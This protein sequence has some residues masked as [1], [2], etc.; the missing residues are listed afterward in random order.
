MGRELVGE[1]RISCREGSALGFGGSLG[2]NITSRCDEDPAE[3]PLI[4]W[5]AS[6][7]SLG[8]NKLPKDGVKGSGG[9]GPKRN[10]PRDG[11]EL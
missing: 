7:T 11:E 5:E 3:S 8:R 9:T 10:L 2:G 1:R 6:V 4:V